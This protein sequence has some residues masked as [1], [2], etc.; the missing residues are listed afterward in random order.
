MLCSDFQ[1]VLLQSDS[2]KKYVFTS[3]NQNKKSSPF[4]WEN[5]AWKSNSLVL[6]RIL[7]YGKKIAFIDA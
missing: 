4:S 7:F 3:Q 5:Q 1:N 2:D 6:Q